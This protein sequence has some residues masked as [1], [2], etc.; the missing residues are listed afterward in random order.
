MTHLHRVGRKILIQYILLEQSFTAHMPLLIS[1]ISF[2]LGRRCWSAFREYYL[3][4]L[5]TI[6][7]WSFD[8]TACQWH[9]ISCVMIVAAQWLVDDMSS[10]R[11]RSTSFRKTYIAQRLVHHYTGC[12]SYFS[13]SW[14]YASRLLAV[15]KYFTDVYSLEQSGWNLRGITTSRYWWPD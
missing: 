11:S 9:D 15:L 7:M 3:H 1:A 14:A 2:H 13:I 8:E 6:M 5:R 10:Y 12:I 4:R